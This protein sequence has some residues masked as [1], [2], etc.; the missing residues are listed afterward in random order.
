MSRWSRKSVRDTE[1]WKPVSIFS[2]PIL[3]NTP[4][5]Q[6]IFHS[7]LQPLEQL[8]WPFF[9]CYPWAYWNCA[10]FSLS[11][12]RSFKPLHIA[13]WMENQLK[14]LTCTRTE[15]GL[16]EPR[17][18]QLME[19]AQVMGNEDAKISGRLEQVASSTNLIISSRLDYMTSWGLF[20]PILWFCKP[21][22]LQL[23][24]KTELWNPTG[25]EDLPIT[26]KGLCL[27]ESNTFTMQPFFLTDSI[28]LSLRSLLLWVLCFV[29]LIPKRPI[30]WAQCG[31]LSCKFH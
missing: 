13:Q 19:F 23:Q 27:Q 3:L 5:S 1:V 12:L 31:V 8:L 26:S 17:S 15:K 22:G 11:L 9:L 28:I 7:S 10:E 4:E 16:R 14:I 30:C 25:K 29:V 24:K 18:P 20:Q 21:L 6:F 2:I